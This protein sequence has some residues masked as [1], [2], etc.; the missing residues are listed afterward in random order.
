[1]RISN[2]RLMPFVGSTSAGGSRSA[3]HGQ[4]LGRSPQVALAADLG[5]PCATLNAMLNNPF[6]QAC[7]G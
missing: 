5:L 6:F 1:M 3:L 4:R 2:R 7:M